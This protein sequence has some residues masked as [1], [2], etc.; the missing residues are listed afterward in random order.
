M[1]KKHLK[2]ALAIDPDNKSL[3]TF[4][5]NLSKMEKVKG[6]AT[7]AFR[8]NE[9]ERAIE[10]YAQCLEFDPLNVAFNQTI[11]Y[12]RACALYNIGQK[13]KA[14]EDLDSAI[15]LNPEYAKAYLKRADI[16]LAQEKYDECLFE[17]NKVKEMAP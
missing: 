8:G 9:I 2:Q 4:W 5:K 6:E 1:G 16:K 3:M 12:N 7:E 13:E 11:Y 17:L 14:L 10:L 15:K